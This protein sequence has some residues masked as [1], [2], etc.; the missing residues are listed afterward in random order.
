MQAGVSRGRIRSGD[1]A[2]FIRMVL[3]GLGVEEGPL[4]FEEALRQAKA[5][6]S[7]TP[8]VRDALKPWLNFGLDSLRLPG[9]YG[10][11]VLAQMSEPSS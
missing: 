11:I 10:T 8:G 4:T 2:D 3:S 5:W 1:G 7:L 6:E 9:V